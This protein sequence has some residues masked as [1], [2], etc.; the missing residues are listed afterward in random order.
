MVG[1][2]ITDEWGEEGVTCH[3]VSIVHRA[4]WMIR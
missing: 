3:V 2:A 4:I 1:G